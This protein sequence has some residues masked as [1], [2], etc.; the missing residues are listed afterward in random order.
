MR[1]G[2][3]EV[4]KGPNVPALTSNIWFNLGIAAALLG[5]VVL[6]AV[7]GVAAL[8][9]AQD[10]MDQRFKE[11]AADLADRMEAWLNDQLAN[12]PLPPREH[13]T[14]PAMHEHNQLWTRVGTEGA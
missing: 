3:E 4:G 12:D 7:A 14:S 11:T 5:I 2:N 6:S 13:R 10:R 9:S 8:P 1:L